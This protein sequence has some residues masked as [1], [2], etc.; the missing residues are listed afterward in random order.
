MWGREGGRNNNKLI[1]HGYGKENQRHGVG[2]DCRGHWERRHRR[3]WFML[4][5]R[6]R[7]LTSSLYTTNKLIKLQ[8][9][10]RTP[11]PEN[12]ASEAVTAIGS[13]VL[14]VQRGSR[15]ND[16]PFLREIATCNEISVRK[17]RWWTGLSRPNHFSKFSQLSF[18]SNLLYY[19][20][21]L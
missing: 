6:L 18:P 11:S 15:E 21:Y 4:V 20:K 7:N 17:S 8:A 19:Q 13:S 5:I 9:Y 10:S 3:F 16:D 12:S 1:K 14:Y 2:F